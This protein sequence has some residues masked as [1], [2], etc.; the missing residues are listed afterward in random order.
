[1]SL[2]ENVSIH[3]F[4]KQNKLKKNGEAPIFVRFTFKKERVEFGLRR[5][6]KPG[7]WDADSGRVTGRSQEVLEINAQLDELSRK[8]TYIKQF[9][10]DDGIE[11]TASNIKKR[12]LGRSEDRHT[13]VKVFKEHNENARKLIGID[14]AE[15]TVIRYQTTLEHFQRFLRQFVKR[16]DISF[17]ELTPKLLDQFEFYFKVERKCSH[18]TTMKYLKNFKKIIRIALANNW[19]SKDPFASKRLKVNPVDTT[20]LTQAELDTLRR[21]ELHISRLESIRDMFLFCCYTGLA[22]IDIKSLRKDHITTDPEDI[23]WI[24]KKRQKTD[25]LSTILVIEAA[26]Q[27]IEKYKY[28]P[29]VACSDKVFPVPTN[30][31]MNAY[32]KEIAIIC[33]LEKRLTTHVGRHTFAT[34]I[35]LE[36]SIPIEVVS[37]VLGHSEI[38]MTQR[39][40]KVTERLMEKEMMKLNDKY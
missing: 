14:F 22:F 6:I 8:V 20:H 3:C 37:K 24:H 25:Q 34:T 18:N 15:E 1:M 36:N 31:K 19:I 11:V 21:Q 38:S 2:S 16:E 5:S 30:Q 9:L 39:Y 26:K 29:E 10:S 27:L 17:K 7:L 35:A 12:L 32:L 40:A 23:T 13:I 28:H 33:R 4:I